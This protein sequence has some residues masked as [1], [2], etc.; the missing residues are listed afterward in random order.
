MRFGEVPIETTREPARAAS[1]AAIS[2]GAP[3]WGRE[4]E[5]SA[6]SSEERVAHRS[7][8]GPDAVFRAREGRRCRRVGAPEEGAEATPDLGISPQRETSSRPCAAGHATHVT[9]DPSA[10]GYAVSSTLMASAS[11]R[12]TESPNSPPLRV[13]PT[14]SK[15]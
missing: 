7:P 8:N 2:F 14:S 3:G 10:S 5:I 11:R 6:P 15:R 1:S 4:I 9:F 13:D 12:A